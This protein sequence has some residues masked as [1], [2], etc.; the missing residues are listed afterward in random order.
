MLDRLLADHARQNYDVREIL[1]FPLQLKSTLWLLFFQEFPPDRA[2]AMVGVV[3]PY[4]D[5]SV[6][7]LV[8][9]YVE[10]TESALSGRLEELDFLAQRLA[11]SNEETERAFMQLRSLYSISQAISSTLDIHETLEAIAVNLAR[12]E[13]IER[14]TIWLATS[15]KTLQVGVTIGP[16]DTP[17]A[18]MTLRL[19]RITSF[20]TEALSTGSEKRFK[21]P[22]D[23]LAPYLKGRDAVALP[24]IS[25]NRPVGVVMISKPH[26]ETSFSSS[27]VSLI[28]AATEQAAIALE[29]AQL[30]GQVMRFNQ[31]L[32]EKVR[33]R[34]AELQK[35]NEELA[36]ANQD[37]EHLDKTKSDFIS[38]AAH[39][40]KTPLTL[41]QGYTN[42]MRDDSTVKSHP[43]LI[44]ILQGIVKGSERLH[45][46]IESMIDVSM[47]DSQVLQL[48]PSQVSLSTLIGT[49]VD[50]Y[51]DVLQE[52]NMTLTMER[53]DRLPHI[54]GDSQRLYQVFE[55]LLVNAVKY[56]PD[57]GRIEI[58][59]MDVLE[60]AGEKW[61]QLVVSDTGIGIDKE[62][63]ERIFEKFYQTAE[64]ALHSTGRTKFKGG[65]PGLGL[66]IAK[67]IVEAHGGQIWAESKGYDEQ[68]CP[69]SQFFVVLPV[70]NRIRI[71]QV[72]SHFSYARSTR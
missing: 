43:F 20:V 70:K 42:I 63:L 28:Q 32:E 57:G 15:P 1:R 2:Q 61:V 31:E 11:V 37:L 26:Q 50:Q 38:I 14:C 22:S 64:V 41:I 52:R 33:R 23:T 16:G 36:K 4:L 51:A 5:Q 45:S 7:L 35:T 25:E 54:E 13:A 3:D 58:T 21:D 17:M 53:L 10:L 44:N 12:L 8:Q 60:Q 67:G 30:Y 19:D 34:T 48:R 71:T 9:G 47:I 65:G 46:I 24:L 55:N 68:A 49:L 69:G 62:H 6:E 56:T 40:L 39:E 29:N 27:T 59:G 66:A 18:N 72:P